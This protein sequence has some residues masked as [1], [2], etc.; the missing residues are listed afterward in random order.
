VVIWK[1]Y[2]QIILISVVISTVISAGTFP[3]EIE[4]GGIFQ[5][6]YFINNY[7]IMPV[8]RIFSQED[9]FQHD[10][11]NDQIKPS[12]VFQLKLR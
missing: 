2:F 8:E 11:E 5:S 3:G 6:F 10:F 1:F 7:S 12:F 4:R 9:N